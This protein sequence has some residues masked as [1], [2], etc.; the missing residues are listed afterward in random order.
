[1][2]EEWTTVELQENFYRDGVKKIIIIFV[3]VFL[4]IG[5][6]I[7]SL[8]YIYL[9]K[10]LPVTFLLNSDWRV[11][12]E[13]PVHQ[14]YLSITDLVQWV[15]N[16]MPKVFTYDF[17]SYNDQLTHAQY[18]FTPNGW[19]TF[20]NY[21]KSYADYTN[22]QKYRQFIS[23]VPKGVPILLN[24]GLLSGRYAWWVQ[25]PIQIT[26]D[27]FTAA[28]SRTLTFQVLVVRVSTLNNL[29]GVGIENIILASPR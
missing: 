15:S 17:I 2:A 6:I 1:M 14:P 23:A 11:Q 25:I 10:P 7:G 24:Q 29:S 19:K 26:Y 8:V 22:V 5:L 12:E 3:G 27:G 13:I 28:P 18:Y 16:V 9:N 21:L 4:S 20:S